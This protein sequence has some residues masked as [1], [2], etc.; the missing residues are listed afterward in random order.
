MKYTIAQLALIGAVSAEQIIATDADE[1]LLKALLKE[2]TQIATP[3]PI[4]G[5][6]LTATDIQGLPICA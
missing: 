4:V 1:Q 2:R 6:T 5:S 3:K